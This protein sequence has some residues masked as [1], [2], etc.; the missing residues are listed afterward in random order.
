MPTEIGREMEAE[1]AWDVAWVCEE[2][3]RNGRYSYNHGSSI[4]CKRCGHIRENLE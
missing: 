4:R 1:S 3:K 2:C